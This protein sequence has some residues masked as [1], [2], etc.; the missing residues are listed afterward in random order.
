M[1]LP[2]TVRD[3]TVHLWSIQKVDIET[4]VSEKKNSKLDTVDLKPLETIEKLFGKPASS[5][6]ATWLG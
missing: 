2:V 6:R 3:V 1:K 4:C 5:E